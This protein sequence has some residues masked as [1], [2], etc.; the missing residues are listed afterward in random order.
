MYTKTV[1][2][3][4]LVVMGVAGSGKTTLARALAERLRLPFADADDYHPPANIAKMACGEPL[5]DDNRAPWLARLAELIEEHAGQAGLVL[6]CSALKRA[7]RERLRATG[8]PITF[9]YLK[10]SFDLIERRLRQ[11]SGHFMTASMLRS[12]F[13]ALEE[14]QHAI[15]V[16]VEL[17]TAEQVAVVV[18]AL[19]TEG[20]ALPRETDWRR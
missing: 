12:Q 18:D 5:D 7:Y 6:A 3:F 17:T 9:V 13:D 2:S 4:E 1:Q 11:R 19:K 10:G 14:P 15:V 16:D 8:T 20:R